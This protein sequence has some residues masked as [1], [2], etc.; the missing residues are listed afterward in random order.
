MKDVRTLQSPPFE[1]YRGGERRIKKEDLNNFD[2]RLRA[3]ENQ[4]SLGQADAYNEGVIL[5]QFA[6]R[7]YTDDLKFYKAHPLVL[8]TGGTSIDMSE[9]IGDTIT[10]PMYDST[11]ND[12][13]PVY[14]Y[15][16]RTDV[17]IW[18]RNPLF[19]KASNDERGFVE[20]IPRLGCHYLINVQCPG[21]DENT[22]PDPYPPS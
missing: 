15:Y 5:V 21:Y 6:E 18:F 22:D 13:L 8:D 4:F 1:R 17:D 7:I 11:A 3:L 14:D 20:F 12:I 19:F 16:E 9:V 10:P 2:A